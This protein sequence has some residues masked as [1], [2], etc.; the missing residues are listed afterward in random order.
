MTWRN[1]EIWPGLPEDS[2]GAEWRG[3]NNSTSRD[4]KAE[5]CRGSLLGGKLSVWGKAQPIFLS[6]KPM[7]RNNR[8][9][10]GSKSEGV[11][12]KKK[13]REKQSQL[14]FFIT[15]LR[16]YLIMNED[17]IVLPPVQME[18]RIKWFL[19]E[20][21]SI[22]AEAWNSRHCSRTICKVSKQAATAHA[23]HSI[24]HIS[25]AQLIICSPSGFLGAAFFAWV[26]MESEQVKKWMT[27]WDLQKRQKFLWESDICLPQGALEIPDTHFWGK[28]RCI[29]IC[30]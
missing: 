11:R 17:L 19:L 5:S 2:C 28:H 22:S 9:G 3:K 27:A 15:V 16:C 13:G 20:T 10:R 26:F 18:L 21:T 29:Q 8:K 14:K 23:A 1:T 25:L 4:I 12:K 30:F 24:Q 6:G 7:K